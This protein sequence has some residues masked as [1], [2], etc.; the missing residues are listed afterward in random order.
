MIT[1]SGSVDHWKFILFFFWENLVVF[2]GLLKKM[3]VDDRIL[4]IIWD[5][6]VIR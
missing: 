4:R 1:D 5:Q 2:W 6:A 3:V